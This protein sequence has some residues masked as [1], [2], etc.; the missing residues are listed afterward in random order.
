M[1]DPRPVQNCRGVRCA[2][3]GGRADG[4]LG[5][6][7]FP[8]HGHALVVVGLVVLEAWRSRVAIARSAALRCFWRLIT[9]VLQG[10]QKR[11]P[12]EPLDSQAVRAVRGAG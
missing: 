11:L 8:E 1:H 10:T 4:A 2:R 7:L 5:R 6:D 3:R 12:K 9:M